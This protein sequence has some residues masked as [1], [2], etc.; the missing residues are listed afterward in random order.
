MPAYC[1]RRRR[2]VTIKPPLEVR[3]AQASRAD[4]GTFVVGS[5]PG[6]TGVGRRV[7]GHDQ[8]SSRKPA[9]A[10]GIFTT[11]YGYAV[12]PTIGKGGVGI[13]GAYG[14]GRVYERG[15]YIGDTS[16][17]QLTVGL[18]ARGPGVQRDHLLRGS[19]RAQGVHQRQL[20]VR[21][22]SLGD[23]DHCGC[24]REGRHDRR[25]RQCERQPRTTPGLR[26][27]YY[28]GMAP[29]TVA[30]GG[31]MFEASIGGQKFNYKPR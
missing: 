11:A 24:R 15:K 7:R 13:G 6:H 4:I 10:P 3:H 23:R 27:G 1:A 17:T 25:I 16:V 12:F 30:K 20:R 26:A 5:G 9:R 22:R 14:T 21:R 31:L 29:F 8:P 2:A 28:K 19:A 18:P